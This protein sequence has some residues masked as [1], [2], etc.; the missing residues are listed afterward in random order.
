MKTSRLAVMLSGSG[1]T[2]INLIGAVARKGLHAEIPLVIGSR[3]CLGTERSR[4]VGIETLV[5]PGDVPAEQLE[6][7]LTSRS[8]DVVALAGYLR[9]LKIPP[10]FQQRIVNIHPALLPAF[11]GRG[12]Y[13]NNVHAAV[14][15]AGCKVSGCTV[16]YVDDAYDRGPII[17]QRAVPILI[18]DNVHALA[19]R[20]FEAECALYPEALQL[21]LT[22][23]V[24]VE[25]ALT[26]ITSA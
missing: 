26:R 23:R 4:A 7:L 25:G 8:I 18:D 21:V 14:L 10:G 9:L 5:I 3:E 6:K 1:R 11:G 13:G 19:A 12:M 15:A 16:H 22:G 24:R 20:V 2:L 17:A